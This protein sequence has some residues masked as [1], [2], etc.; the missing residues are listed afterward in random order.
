MQ[1]IIHNA[2]TK[3]TTALLLVTAMF[4]G[5]TPALAYAAC[6]PTVSFDLWAK[7]GT[8]T[9]YTGGPTVNIWGYSD[10]SAGVATLPGPALGKDADATAPLLADAPIVQGDCVGI[11][12]HNDNI[13]GST[14]LLFQGQSIVPDRTGVSA[15]NST[16]YTFT[17]SKPGTFLYEAGLT[18]NGQHQVAMGMYGALIVRPATAGQAYNSASTAFDSEAVVVL[19]EYDATL[20]LNPVAFDMRK[21]APK[22]FLIN[23]KAYP[24]TASIFADAGDA[25][26]L[27]YVNAGLTS[28][29]MGILGLSQ[30]VVGQDGSPFTYS[31]KMISETI[32]PGQTL[33]AIVTIPSALTG[34]KYALYDSNLLLRNT[35][36]AGFGGMLTFLTVGAGGPPPSDTTGPLLSSVTLSPN[37]SDDT[38]SVALSA[39]ASETI[40][41]NANVTAWEYS[42]DAVY[43]TI[44]IGSP[45]TVQTLNATIPAGLT[46]GSHPVTVRAQDTLGNWSSTTTINLVVDNMGPTTSGL[47]LT[48]NP[49]NGSVGVTFSFTGNDTASGNSNITAAEYWIDP[50]GTP[51]SGTGT[52]VSVASPAPVKTLNVGL[53]PPFSPGSH[54]ISVHSQDAL[55][56]WG[57][58][59]TINLV[60]DQTGPVTSNVIASPNPN[61]GLMAFN[62]TVQAVRVT[63]SFSDSA[64]GGSNIAV[65]E[66]FIDTIGATGTGFAFSAT[67]GLFNSSNENGY[68]DIPLA[69]VNALSSG[70]HTIY[71]HARDASGNWNNTLPY[72]STVLTIN[73]SLYFSTLGNTNPPGV[74]GTADDADIYLYNGTAF[75]R[76]IDVTAITNPLPSGANVDGF[77]RVDATHFYMSFNGSVTLPGP[78]AVQDEDVVY[79]NAGTWSLY[80]DG[81]VNGVTSNLDAI[82]I[83]SGN[84]Y[85][86][87]STTTLPPGVGGTGDDADIY[88]WNSLSSYTRVV[89]ANGA[90]SLGLPT[91]ANVDG[92]VWVDA[93]H[94]YMS[95]TTDTA[96]PGLGTAQDEDVVYYNGSIWSTYFDGTAKGLTANNQDIDAFDIP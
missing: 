88:R 55:G 72:A 73:R 26:L 50:V 71:V 9:L 8:A 39:T 74:A 44:T 82:S 16:L 93:T 59:V 52:S 90:G 41:G 4:S 65:V 46:H 1:T 95:F 30:T 61:N 64:S 79:Y 10:T 22:Y 23:G 49:S 7:T 2:L 37:P 67:D 51:A 27:R 12:L 68:V 29:H 75:S 40:T 20:A 13:P 89:D 6:A 80:Y 32:A 42:V 87:L 57:A 92:F 83:V 14:S 18:P 53:L 86:S 66:G 36:A 91:G 34:T 19:S 58:R 11:T 77:D 54:V 84:L 85:F 5:L 78:L 76:S 96:V 28:H 31:H 70:N 48:P 21:Y 45:T 43:T 62:T 15:G 47:S 63:A 17:A 69:V 25:V 38:G 60:V 81:S 33:D 3:L 24:G 94:F 35:N 56:N